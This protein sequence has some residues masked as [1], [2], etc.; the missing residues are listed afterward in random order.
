MHLN[1]HV[2]NGPRGV[3]FSTTQYGARL[4]TEKDPHYAALVRD[5]CALPFVFVGTRLDESPLWQELE[6]VEGTGGDEPRLPR[7]RSLLVTPQ[8][9]R[10]RQSL[11]ER[12]GVSWVP[13]TTRQFT[14]EVLLPIARSLGVA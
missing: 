1:G 10:A 5:F 3:T 6:R 4:A 8:I 14:D 11:L 13:H 7:P 12:L 2:Q 9:E